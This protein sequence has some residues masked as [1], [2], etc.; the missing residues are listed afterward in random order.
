M[1]SQYLLSFEKNQSNQMQQYSGIT[2]VSAD[3][4]G[5]ITFIYM[6]FHPLGNR[7]MHETHIKKA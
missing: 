5:K 1:F 7:S 4:V 2:S 6:N 3:S